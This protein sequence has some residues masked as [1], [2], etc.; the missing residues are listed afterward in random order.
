MYRHLRGQYNVA[1]G[2]EVLVLDTTGASNTAIGDFAMYNHRD[3][4]NN[5]AV[6][7][8]ALSGNIHG[9]DNTVIGYES[10]G[11]TQGDSN[12][13][14]GNGSAYFANSSNKLYIENSRADSNSAFIYGD[15]AADSLSLNAK[16]N[17]RDYTRLGTIASGAPAIKMKKLT[18]NSAVTSNGQA[19]KDHGL[20]SSKI[21]SVTTLMEWTPGYFAPTEYSP[22]PLLRYNY[23]VSPTQIFIQNN[24]ASCAYICNKV[25]KII[26][27]YEE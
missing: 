1:V 6:G 23:F 16:V 17:V 15:F 20:N 2:N 14:I 18:L 13:Y 5:V 9:S 11:N 4:V 10:G 7:T 19:S 8:N 27:T 12:I 25:V 22:D 26:I 24:A 21:I 3:G